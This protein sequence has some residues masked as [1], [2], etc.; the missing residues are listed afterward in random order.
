MHPF[1]WKLGN[2]ENTF[3]EILQQRRKPEVV[4]L[5]VKLEIVSRFTVVFVAYL[6]KWMKYKTELQSRSNP[7]DSTFMKHNLIFPSNFDFAPNKV[8][9]LLG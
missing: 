7:D 6:R 3:L 4:C 9:D 8:T 2:K 5:M 1:H